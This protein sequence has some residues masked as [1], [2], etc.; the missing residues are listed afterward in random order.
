M[1]FDNSKI[2]NLGSRKGNQQGNVY[3]QGWGA[4]STILINWG[5]ERKEWEKYK[6]LNRKGYKFEERER[7]KGNEGQSTWGLMMGVKARVVL[8]GKP[9]SEEWSIRITE[10]WFEGNERLLLVVIWMMLRRIGL[11]SKHRLLSTDGLRGYCCA[12]RKWKELLSVIAE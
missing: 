6:G 9:A 11:G 8:W 12:S 2:T 10:D 7:G 5:K 1:I 4:K 3:W